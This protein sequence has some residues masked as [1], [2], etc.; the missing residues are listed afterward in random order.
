MD[1]FYEGASPYRKLFAD[2]SDLGPIQVTEQPDIGLPTAVNQKVRNYFQA[3]Q[4]K[5][6]CAHL[7]NA[8]PKYKYLMEV[9]S[10]CVRHLRVLGP[11]KSTPYQV[12][13]EYQGTFTSFVSSQEADIFIPEAK[14]LKK[15]I[16]EAK[17]NR[18][19]FAVAQ[20]HCHY[21]AIQPDTDQAN[22]LFATVEMGLME[23]DYDGIRPFLT[24]FEVLLETD[25][26][27]FTSMRGSKLGRF[28]QVMKANENY[29]K[30][31][32]TVL[33]FVFKLV[34]RNQF[35]RDWFYKNQ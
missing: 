13:K 33:E 2:M 6:R 32:E 17:R 29:Y 18:S 9:V 20:A 25:H 19:A 27:Y 15:F 21:A 24:L 35:A 4:E 10:L 30:W 11:N 28:I 1:F 26:E 8:P 5:R 3:L 34:G 16:G 12:D 14:F 22:E 23:N 31:T 7:M